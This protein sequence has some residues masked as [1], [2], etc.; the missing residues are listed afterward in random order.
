MNLVIAVGNLVKDPELKM[1]SDNKAVVNFTI[2]VNEGKDQAEFIMV[3]AW[4][5]NAENICKYLHKGSKLGIVGKL[6][7]SSWEDS[8]GKHQKTY[9]R[10]NQVEFLSAK[11]ETQQPKEEFRYPSEFQ[12]TN[13]TGGNRDVAGY[14]DEEQKGGYIDIKNDDLPFY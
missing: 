9:V 3:Q 8:N 6:H 11:Q 7:T 4:E 5:R 12:Q 13:L 1:A 2:A 10:V 14:Q